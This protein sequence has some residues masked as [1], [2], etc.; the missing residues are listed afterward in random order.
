M[1]CSQ[2]PYDKPVLLTYITYQAANCLQAHLLALH[3]IQGPSQNTGTLAGH[4]QRDFHAFKAI[5]G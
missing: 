3:N 4:S 1:N 5:A 2:T